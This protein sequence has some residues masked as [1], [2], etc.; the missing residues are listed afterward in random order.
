VGA[1][2]GSVQHAEGGPGCVPEETKVK[3]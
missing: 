3:P 2:V 1:V